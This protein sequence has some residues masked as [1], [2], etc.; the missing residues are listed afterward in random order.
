VGEFERLKEQLTR[1]RLSRRDFI[2]RA[3]LLGISASALGSILAAC[4]GGDN[5][6][7]GANGSGGG[8]ASG[9]TLGFS[10]GTL[11]QRRWQFDKQYVEEHAKSLGMEVQVQSAEDDE[12]LQVS[13]VENLVAQGIDVLILS[14]INV[15]TAAPAV[16]TAKQAGVPV[17]SY[18]SLVLNS[19]V[20]YW[21]ARD[22]VLVGRIQAEA[23]V[24]K[25][26]EGNYVICSGEPGVDIAQEKTAGNMEILQPYIDDGAI[27]IISQEYHRAWDPASGL[28][29]VEAALAQTNNKIDAVL[30]NYD[31]FVLA[32]LE[33][34]G[35]VG[36]VGKTFLGGEDVFE[37][38][39]QAIVE[40]RAD[41]SAYTD[42]REMATKAVDAAAALAQGE[43]PASDDTIDNGAGE[44]P[45]SRISSFA[46]T[47][48]NM[49]QFLKDTDWLEYETVY[50]N[51]PEGERPEC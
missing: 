26:P 6:E 14:P 25:V 40:R 46:V 3:T 5:G 1:G 27:T 7:G 12:R 22:N 39:A 31:G 34:L 42:L 11:A 16:S 48:D 23:A 24:A 28:K 47:A 30:G 19:D 15:E 17:I 35:E 4:G 32:A 36:L 2:R 38:V 41:M 49:C 37:E 8:G 44:I 50:A 51:V 9:L 29:Q 13:Q 45:G 21:V 43:Q 20:D 33:A 10:L 18:N